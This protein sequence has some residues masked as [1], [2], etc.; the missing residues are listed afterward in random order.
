VAVQLEVGTRAAKGIYVIYQLYMISF[1][2]YC[3]FLEQELVSLI[4]LL[5]THKENKY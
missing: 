4:K 2:I 5:A 3:L 1:E